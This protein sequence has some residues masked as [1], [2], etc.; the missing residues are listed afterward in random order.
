MNDKNFLE[1]LA[2][3]LHDNASVKTVFGEPVRAGDKVIIPVARIMFGMGGGYGHGTQQTKKLLPPD[4]SQTSST[5][6]PGK[7]G[8]GAG[9]GGGMRVIAKGVYE[10]TPK[11]TR[12]IPAYDPK[13]ILISL[14]AGFLFGQLVVSRLVGKRRGC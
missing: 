7:E 5:D 13:K 12:F 10:I 8:E 2:A 1:T 9:G 14:V 11:A 4:S 6:K 3:S